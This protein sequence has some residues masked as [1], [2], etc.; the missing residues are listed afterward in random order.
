MQNKC[1]QLKKD[2]EEASL[3]CMYKQAACSVCWASY[4][5]GLPIGAGVYSMGIPTAWGG[6]QCR[7]D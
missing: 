2:L 4:S 3:T 1:D 6:I 5:V 7:A